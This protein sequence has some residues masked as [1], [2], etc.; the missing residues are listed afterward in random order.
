MFRIIFLSKASFSGSLI[1]KSS[2]IFMGTLEDKTHSVDSL[3]RLQNTCGPSIP[4]DVCI[5]CLRCVV[6]SVSLCLSTS[7]TLLFWVLLFGESISQWQTSWRNLVQN[8]ICWIL[9]V[10]GLSDDFKQSTGKTLFSWENQ[11]LRYSFTTFHDNMQT[12][13]GNPKIVP[14][15]KVSS[16]LLFYGIE[17]CWSTMQNSTITYSS[18]SM[19]FIIEIP[20][21][22]QLLIWRECGYLSSQPLVAALLGWDNVNSYNVICLNS[23]QLKYLLV[24]EA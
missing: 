8:K 5:S 22:E 7:G 3:I 11:V 18:E 23:G 13:I 4:V 2:E 19:M 1:I 6:L 21:Q 12:F 16:C 20:S 15:L 24:C 17:I 14:G 10:R 9:N